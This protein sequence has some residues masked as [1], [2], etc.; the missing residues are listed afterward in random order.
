MKLLSPAPGDDQRPRLEVGG[1]RVRARLDLGER[2]AVQGVE[3][4]GPVDG[5]HRHR[6]APLD[7][8][9]LVGLGLGGRHGGLEGR[10]RRRAPRAIRAPLLG[11]AARE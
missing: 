5:H 9:V 4:V 10:A 11:R 7:Q 3:D 2:F 1:E 6:A 8:Q